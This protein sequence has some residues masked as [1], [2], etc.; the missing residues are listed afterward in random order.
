M[1]KQGRYIPGTI[2]E[3]I[4]DVESYS[5]CGKLLFAKGEQYTMQA[6][7]SIM[8]ETGHNIFYIDSE[9]FKRRAFK[10]IKPR[11]FL[12]TYMI[13]TGPTSFSV[14]TASVKE[15]TGKYINNKELVGQLKKI[16]KTSDTIIITNI[17]ELSKEDYDEYNRK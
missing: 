2:L 11:Y 9:L 17:I 4:G 6:D 14:A 16:N 12:V 5:D 1:E 3:C 13:Q 7:Y 8:D 15:D 10:I